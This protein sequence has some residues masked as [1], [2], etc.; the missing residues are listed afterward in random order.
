MQ[1]KFSPHIIGENI[2]MIEQRKYIVFIK[3]IKSSLQSNL[4]LSLKK[5]RQMF[6]N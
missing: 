6:F 5:Y 3:G 1:Y 2:N 4:K